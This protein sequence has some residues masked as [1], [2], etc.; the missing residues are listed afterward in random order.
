MMEMIKTLKLNL[1]FKA[2]LITAYIIGIL[3]LSTVARAQVSIDPVFGE[4]PQMA[5]STIAGEIVMTPSYEF[6][7]IVDENEVY[8][9]A[10]NVDLSDYNGK[11]VL[12]EGIEAKNFQEPSDSFTSLDP[13]PLV[14]ESDGDRKL[15][16]V[17]GIHEV[18]N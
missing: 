16:V 4:R 9:L 15:F 11:S 12:V 18:S 3:V 17:L 14:G 5:M 13:L 1:N 2:I 8:K 10:T 6:F 7:L